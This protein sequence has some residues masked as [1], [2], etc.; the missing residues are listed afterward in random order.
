M[1][2]TVLLWTGSAVC[3]AAGLLG[4][5]LPVLPGP[6]L[7]FVGILFAAWAEDFAYLGTGTLT[8][9]GVLAVLG[10]ALDFLAGAYGARRYRASGRAVLGA[11]LG[12]VIGV[13]FG[14]LGALLGPFVGAVVGQLAASPDLWAAGRAGAGAMVGLALGTAAKLAVGLAMVALALAMRFL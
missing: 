2:T 5:A 10:V 3:T 9:L 6:P 8:A 7:L 13:F 11:T 4:L 12:A 14:P 1:V